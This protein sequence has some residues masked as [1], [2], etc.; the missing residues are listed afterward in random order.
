MRLPD[1]YA[2]RHG[3][4]QRAV[5]LALVRAPELF[6]LLGAVA[7]AAW[8]SGLLALVRRSSYFAANVL[9]AM[10]WVSCTA[11]MLSVLPPPFA[12]G[13]FE[14]A[15]AHAAFAQSRMIYSLGVLV[16][17]VQ[18]VLLAAAR[19]LAVVRERRW[20]RAVLCEPALAAAVAWV[21]VLVPVRWMWPSRDAPLS[22]YELIL[23]CR[24]VL[25]AA[26]AVGLVQAVIGAVSSRR[27][28]RVKLLSPLARSS[29]DGRD[30]GRREDRGPR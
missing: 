17:A 19:A 21:A 4:W 29:P 8:M 28:A 25:L 3:G 14:D 1:L 22:H 15:G 7:A 2:P 13:G 6:V 26:I 30:T 11:A 27:A 9:G 16:V 24:Y 20:L 5:A 23:V 10:L 12:P 18:V